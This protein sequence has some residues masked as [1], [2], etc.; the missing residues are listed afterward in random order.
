MPSIVVPPNVDM[1]PVFIPQK[2]AYCCRP[3][4]PG[5]RW[6]REKIYRPATQAEAHYLRYHADLL[7]PEELSCWEK[8]QLEQDVTRTARRAA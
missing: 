7:A 2:C 1:D 6:V 5:Q 8:H 4:S 3:I